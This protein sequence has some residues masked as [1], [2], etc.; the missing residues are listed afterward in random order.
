MVIPRPALLNPGL[1]GVAMNDVP[2]HP[3]RKARSAA[4]VLSVVA[5]CFSPAFSRHAGE[6]LPHPRSA[7]C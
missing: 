2:A 6:A 7:G 4:T 3:C 5:G 1:H